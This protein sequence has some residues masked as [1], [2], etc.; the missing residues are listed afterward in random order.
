[1]IKRRY[2]KGIQNLFDVF[3]HLID[4]ALIIDNSYGKQE[5]L[6]EKNGSLKIYNQV[7]FETLKKIKQ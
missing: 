5:L 6:A 1:M 3:L 4:N 2:K 7:K